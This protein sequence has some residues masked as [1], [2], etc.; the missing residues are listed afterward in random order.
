LNQNLKTFFLF[1]SAAQNHC[2]PV[3]LVAHLFF[4]F[5]SAP[6]QVAF[7]PPGHSSPP[8]SLVPPRSPA[9]PLAA[10]SHPPV[11]MRSRNDAPTGHLLFPY[12]NSTPR[13]LPSP[14]YSLKPA[15]LSSTEP[16]P[17]YSPTASLLPS[18]PYK[19]HPRAPSPH[20]LPIPHI[21]SPSL[22]QTAPPQRPPTP[23]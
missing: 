19:S 18:L 2:G 8:Q 10:V 15:E 7:G 16:P 4:C 17:D 6:A 22:G 11:R 5:L 9:A 13:R 21:V 20:H 3:V 1:L 14:Y 12:T 23:R